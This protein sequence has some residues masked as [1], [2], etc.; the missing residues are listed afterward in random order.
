MN[1]NQTISNVMYLVRVGAKTQIEYKD[2]SKSEFYETLSHFEYIFNE[3]KTFIR[4][5]RNCI[6][7]LQFVEMYEVCKRSKNAVV[8]VNGKKFIVSR[9]SLQQ[10]KQSYRVGTNIFH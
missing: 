6:I 5:H 3:L 10:F 4:I 2:G 9:R 7:N 8:T 1:R